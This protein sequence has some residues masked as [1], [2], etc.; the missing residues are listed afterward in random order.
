MVRYENEIYQNLD[1]EKVFVFNCR[2]P[3]IKR[4]VDMMRSES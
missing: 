2:A 4:L 3:I 1:S